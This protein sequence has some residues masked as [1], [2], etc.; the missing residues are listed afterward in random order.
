MTASVPA[1]SDL[2]VAVM[3]IKVSESMIRVINYNTLPVVLV[4]ISLYYT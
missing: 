3:L 2:Y 4:V 1:S